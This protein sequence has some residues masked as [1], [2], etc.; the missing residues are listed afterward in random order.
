[1]KILFVIPYIASTYGGPAKVVKELSHSL[2]QIDVTVDVITTDADV[3]GKLN[4]SLNTWID[5]DG[6]R[7]QYFKCLNRND[8]TVSLPLLAWLY[9]NIKQYDIV[10]TNNRFAPLILAT[11][12]ICRLFRKPFVATPHGMLEPWALSYKAYKKKW[13]YKLFEYPMLSQAK[14]IHVLTG[15]EAQQLQS[16]GL[17]GT[18]VIPNG[19][20]P[21]E[22]TQM[23]ESNLFYEQFPETRGKKIILFLGRID[24]K[25]GLNLLV[26]AFAKVHQCYP[27]L[28]LVVV[29][30]D[31]IGFLK[32]VQS[33]LM[34]AGCSESITFTGMLTGQQKLAALAAAQVF[35]APSYSEGFSMSVLEGMAAGLPCILTTGCNFPEAGAAGAAYVVDINEDAI[36]QALQDCLQ[37]PLQAKEMGDRARD[38]IFKHYTWSIVAQ[39]LKQVYTDIME[40]DTAL[41]SWSK[42]RSSEKKVDLP[43]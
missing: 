34:D 7:I 14:A 2:S 37:N 22:F 12:W 42:S 39:Q 4:V 5:A 6:F 40:V 1:M 26:P 29:G 33:D 19:I 31:S 21:L 3:E 28:Q 16:L 10:H 43:Y 20:D 35:V 30:P 9:Q 32:T 15:S 23:P 13:Y 27:D 18:V 36:T 24:P 8:L 38:F 25:K 17:S 11:E 41:L